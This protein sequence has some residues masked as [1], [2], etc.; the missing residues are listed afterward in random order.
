MSAPRSEA[1]STGQPGKAR[2]GPD[3]AL[4]TGFPYFT[5]RRMIAKI[6]AADPK[7]EVTLLVREKFRERAEA[8]AAALPLKP[9]R[10]LRLLI[11]DVCDIDLGLSGEEYRELAAEVTTI[12]HVA[13]AYYLRVPRDTA[14]RVNVGG[15]RHVIELAGSCRRLERLCHFSAASVS[16]T[17][18]G[19]IM[20]DELELRQ[21][22]HNAY[23]ET[24][25]RAEAL[26]REAARR[27]PVT[28]L[29]PGIIVG[30]SR[31]G[32]IEKLDGPYYLIKLIVGSRLDVALPLPGQGSAPL[33]LVPIDY[34]VDAAFA[35][36]RDPRAVG[37]TFHLV[38]PCPLAARR[39]Y[40]LV[41]ERASRKPPKGSIPEGLARAALS[42]PGLSRLARVPLDFLES[43]N[44]LAFYNCQNTLELLAPDLACPP[45]E[46][47]VD[48]LVRYVRDRQQ[49]RR[50]AVEEQAIDPLD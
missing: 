13:S 25:Y 31:T 23:E 16:G 22:F 20:E 17:R 19:V 10:R 18:K 7:A 29:R 1:E 43:F 40:E 6:L 28:I 12:Y 42:L 8:F 38:D 44:H 34:V 46:K 14:L 27:L 3:V 41:A 11:G 47:Y 45:F 9:R 15:T 26:A 48:N 35:L 2:R 4:V 30:D 33:Y 24:K 39:V 21:R 49:Q 5:A 50:Q 36:A 37:R 32:E